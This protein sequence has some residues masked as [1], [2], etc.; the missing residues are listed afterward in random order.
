MTINIDYLPA[1]LRGLV[2]KMDIAR[3]GALSAFSFR[4]FLR[5]YCGE[6]LARPHDEREL[7][8][9]YTELSRRLGVSSNGDCRN[10]GVN[11]LEKCNFMTLL[12]ANASQVIQKLSEKLLPR[13]NAVAQLEALEYGQKIL[14][15][16]V[17]DGRTQP[18]EVVQ[19]QYGDHVNIRL[20]GMSLVYEKGSGM[21]YELRAGI[22]CDVKGLNSGKQVVEHFKLLLNG[23]VVPPQNYPQILPDFLKSTEIF[24]GR[25]G[26]LNWGL[27]GTGAIPFDHDQATLNP[28]AIMHL[29]VLAQVTREYP[30]IQLDI[31][32]HTDRTGTNQYNQTLGKKRAQAVKRYLTEKM[33][34]AASSRLMTSSRGASDS[35]AHT[36]EGEPNYYNRNVQ[37]KAYSTVELPHA[38]LKKLPIY[39][40]ADMKD[41]F[42]RGTP[43]KYRGRTV[44]EVYYLANTL[45]TDVRKI[46]DSTKL[47]KPLPCV[48][49]I[50]D[51][52]ES[53]KPSPRDQIPDSDGIES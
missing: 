15:A 13:W 38:D 52:K 16:Y 50:M 34:F 41:N 10:L 40:K 28:M 47:E 45:T 33:G 19:R 48:I 46:P 30:S 39:S 44:F 12:F 43:V 18:Y 6:Y 26:Q 1:D 3:G 9:T 2:Q 21:E 17:M 27:L 25:V 8:D 7:C 37:I 29:G 5:E 42:V 24:F 49:P 11:L 14:L 53:P 23:E 36:A 31:I 32:G 51:N 20:D 4:H 35:L 22:E